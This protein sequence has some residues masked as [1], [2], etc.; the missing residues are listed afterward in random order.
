MF[1]E[2]RGLLDGSHRAPGARHRRLELPLPVPRRAGARPRGGDRRRAR[3]GAD[4]GPRGVRA[5]RP[6]AGRGG[7]DAGGRRARAAV[8]LRRAAGGCWRWATAARPPTRWMSS[9]TCVRPP[10]GRRPR[11]ALDLTEDTGILTAIANDI[12]VEAIFSRQVIAH[13]R[14][15]RRAAR[16]I[17]ERRLGQRAST[18]SPRRGGEAWSRSRSSATTAGAS[19]GGP[20]RPRGGR[21]LRAHPPHPGGAGVAPTTCCASWSRRR[22]EARA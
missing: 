1:F 2:H 6:D 15:R 19:P 17:D 20:G 13:G 16:A 7:A 11:P 12:G 10:D 9:P 3:V 18:R 4:E 5:A 14:S 22:G 8:L 21:P